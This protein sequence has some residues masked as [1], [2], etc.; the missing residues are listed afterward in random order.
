VG[1]NAQLDA[2]LN[3]GLTQAADDV[4]VFIGVSRRF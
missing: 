3:L 4:G 2:G 1:A